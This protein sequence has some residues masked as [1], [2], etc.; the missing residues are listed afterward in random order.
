MKITISII[1]LALL[2]ISCKNTGSVHHN[3]DST[4]T[5]QEEFKVVQDSVKEEHEHNHDDHEHSH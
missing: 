3:N 1:A 5:K 2:A 4:A